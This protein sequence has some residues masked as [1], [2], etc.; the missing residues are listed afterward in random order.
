LANLFFAVY[1]EE[2]QAYN[3]GSSN[4][5][6]ITLNPNYNGVCECFGNQITCSAQYFLSNPA[7]IYAFTH[8]LM[9]AVQFSKFSSNILKK[10]ASFRNV[11]LKLSNWRFQCWLIEGI[12]DYARSQ[13]GI[14]N[15]ASEWSLTLYAPDSHIQMVTELRPLS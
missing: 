3:N 10:S 1:P 11:R 9:H 12:A 14:R 7:D 8:E 5:V 6:V 2:R 15:D 13:F 4:N